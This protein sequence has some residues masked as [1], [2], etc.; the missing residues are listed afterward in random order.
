MADDTPGKISIKKQKQQ[1][2]FT[3][4]P[5]QLFMLQDQ[6][7]G[8]T[9]QGVR[10]DEEIMNINHNQEVLCTDAETRGR[11]EVETSARCYSKSF[12]SMVHMTDYS[13]KSS[14]KLPI[15]FKPQQCSIFCLLDLQAPTLYSGENKIVKA[16]T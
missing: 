15:S 4:D 5:L 14:Y 6:D 16:N 3:V 2:F 13:T 11:E 12:C 9:R 10:D 1:N 7:L 8:D